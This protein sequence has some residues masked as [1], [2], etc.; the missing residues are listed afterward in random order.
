MIRD[1]CDT[2]LEVGPCGICFFFCPNSLCLIPQIQP[3][4]LGLCPIMPVSADYLPNDAQVK[5]RNMPKRILTQSEH[6]QHFQKTP[7]IPRKCLKLPALHRISRFAY[8]AETDT[9]IFRL[10]LP[11][12]A[13]DHVDHADVGGGGGGDGGQRGAQIHRAEDIRVRAAGQLHQPPAHHRG[14][15]VQ[16]DPIK[17]TLKAP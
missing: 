8:Y 1:Q 17:P 5:C 15:A 7:K 3:I 12:G 9:G 4:V 2:F 6:G 10:A 11:G 16:V 13:R 14:R